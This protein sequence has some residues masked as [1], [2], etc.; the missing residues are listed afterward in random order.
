MKEELIFAAQSE[1]HVK[2][3]ISAMLFSMTAAII[4]VNASAEDLPI[5]NRSARKGALNDSVKEHPSDLSR[6]IAILMKTG[7][8][9][10]L[11]EVMSQLIGLTGTPSTKG[12]DFTVPRNKDTERRECTVVF[13]NDS[14]NGGSEGEKHPA[15]LYIQHKI[16]S[17]HDSE[18]RYY[19]FSPDGKLEYAVINHAKFQD[20]EEVM[21][22]G[23]AVEK[24]INSP[25]VQKSF[26]A[27]LAYWTKEWLKKEQRELAKAKTASASA[28]EVPASPAAQ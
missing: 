6:L 9:A 18:A 15:C 11:P 20:N 19:R 17:G 14:G 24:D 22:S 21:G 26:K 25:D 10:P 1:V 5:G 12:R 3:S 4:L 2:R 28:K 7:D 13:S 8:D 27:E 23:V 16:I